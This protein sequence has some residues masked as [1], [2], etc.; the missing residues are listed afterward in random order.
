MSNTI[1]VTVRTQSEQTN[2]AVDVVKGSG[3]KGQPTRIRAI[4]DARYQLQDVDNNNVAPEKVNAKRM[5]KNLHLSFGDSKEADLII[6]G[7]YD[8][9]PL[10]D[11]GSNI[12]GQ[13]TDGSMYEYI[14]GTSDSAST[15]ATL[16]DGG[17]PMLQVLSTEAVAFELSSLPLAAAV[18]PAYVDAAVIAVGASTTLTDE[19]TEPAELTVLRNAAQNNNAASPAITAQTYAAAGVTG[20]TD[21]NVDAIN[22]ALN[23]AAIAGNGV[24]SAAQLQAIVNAYNAILAENNNPSAADPSAANYAATR[25]C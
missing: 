21:A 10:G 2:Q 13:S 16:S 14:S 8:A 17:K 15:I 25:N 19:K 3:Q 23:T 11:A 12:Y 24:V 7:Y 18:L 1:K 6:D 5:G 22:S 4:K 20:V 9:H